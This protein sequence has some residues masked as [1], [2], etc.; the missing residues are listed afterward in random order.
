MCHI[1]DINHLLKS[2]ESRGSCDAS[3]RT[4][5]DTEAC[6]EQVSLG[7]SALKSEVRVQARVNRTLESKSLPTASY[8]PELFSV[9]EGTGTL[10]SP[11]LILASL[12]FGN[13]MKRNKQRRGRLGGT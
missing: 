9:L 1:P 2:A 3:R 5:E 4:G 12:I 10:A 8:S 7:H 11:K 13:C 6:R